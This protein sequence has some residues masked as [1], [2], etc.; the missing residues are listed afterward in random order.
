MTIKT[1]ITAECVTF[2]A[3]NGRRL[4][5]ATSDFSESI[6]NYATLHGLK[7]KI[8]DAGAISRNPDTGRS[9]TDDDK[10]DAMQSVLDVLLS[11]NWNKQRGDG[12]TTSGGLLFR[13]LCL[14]YATKTPEA[15]RTFLDSKTNEEKA[16]LRKVPSIAAQIETLK[17]ASVKTDGIDVDSLLDGLAD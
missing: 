10:L 9:A 2:E 7:Q 11:G 14:V 12:T 5:A 8:G 13:A 4:V 15:I 3:T 6:L 1:T 16:A 17:A